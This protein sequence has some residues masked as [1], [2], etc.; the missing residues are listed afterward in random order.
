MKDFSILVVDDDK[1]FLRGIIR[2]LKK[3]LKK[4]ILSG[5]PPEIKPLISFVKKRSVSCFRIF[6]CPEYQVMISC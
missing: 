3:S 5:H 4:L 2:N 6:V 1:D